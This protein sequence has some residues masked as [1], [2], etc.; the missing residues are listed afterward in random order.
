MN[1]LE[2][3]EEDRP[4]EKLLNLGANTMSDAELIALILSSG[5]KG[6][7]AL[8]LSQSLIKEAGT[9]AEL[10]NFPIQKL[11]SHKNLGEAKA[12]KI[13]AVRELATRYNNKNKSIVRISAPGDAYEYIKS[14]LSGKETEHL[15][16]IALNA[17]NTIINKS[18]IS[19]GTV[20]ET[21]IHPREIIK[22]AVMNNAVSIILVHNHPSGEPYP[23]TEDIKVTHRLENACK[24]V[25][26]GFTDHIIV[27]DSSY[28][29]MRAQ[30]LLGGG[31]N[32]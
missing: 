30:N 19:V 12:V 9:L 7:S 2:L 15:Y 17:R 4:R 28:S 22:V 18:L 6:Q 32:N 1:I 11:V 21:L 5:G 13:S 25:G 29:S 27:C 26:I 20:N 3:P 23:S 24:L 31:E 10:L 14:S 8:E 16:L